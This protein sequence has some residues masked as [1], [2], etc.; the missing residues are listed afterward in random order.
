MVVIL[1]YGHGGVDA[2]GKYTTAPAKQ[3]LVNGEWVYEGVL[4]RT[5][6]G[7]LHHLLD[8]H[9]YEVIETVAVEDARDIPLEDRVRT[10]NSVNKAIM[11]S[12]HCNAFNGKARGFE[13]Y[14]TRGQNNSDKLAE[15]IASRVDELR[16]D[17]DVLMR[18]DTSDGDMDKEID[19]YVIRKSKH[20][21][22]LVECLFFDN[23]EDLALYNNMAF[24][25]QFVVALYDGIVEYIESRITS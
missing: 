3:A 5:I 7:M 19:F 25:Q 17:F 14:T 4:N 1:D 12:I 10:I 8:W 11:V 6:G 20:P 16:D 2:N 24:R 23:P 18:L 21:A 22:V 15:S 13:I 9:G